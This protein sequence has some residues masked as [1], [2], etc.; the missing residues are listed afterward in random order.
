MLRVGAGPWI[1]PDIQ[2]R[3]DRVDGDLALNA[4]ARVDADDLEVAWKAA[5][6]DTPQEPALSQLVEHG[7]AVGQ[8]KRVVVG[9][10]THTRTKL[11]RAGALQ[12]GADED[13]RGGDVLPF[14]GEVFADPG[15]VKA[16]PIEVF[17]LGEVCLERA[18]DVGARRMHRHHEVPELHAPI[19]SMRTLDLA[20][21]THPGR[22]SLQPSAASRCSARKLAA[23]SF[24]RRP[25]A[26]VLSARR[27]C[28]TLL[29]GRL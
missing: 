23:R 9:Q 20:C 14:G 11:D 7:D 2:H 8:V 16:E 24:P 6:A 17:D 1:V 26:Y 25:P 13:V 15:L 10:T 18:S 5:R 28:M 22:G 3:V 27:T 29:R 21:P 12:R 19:G 4:G